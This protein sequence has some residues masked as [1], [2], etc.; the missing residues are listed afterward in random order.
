MTRRVQR[1]QHAAVYCR[2][3]AEQV[4]DGGSSLTLC[5]FGASRRSRPRRVD[6]ASEA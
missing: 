5:P 2:E 1:R 4:E 6:C 3:T